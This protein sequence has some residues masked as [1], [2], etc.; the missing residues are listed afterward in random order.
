MR[1]ALFIF[2]VLVSVPRAAWPQG[3]PLGP[4]FRVNTCT[5][6]SFAPFV[7]PG[8]RPSRWPRSRT[9]RRSRGSRRS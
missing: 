2:V 4:A 5:L 6:I 9:S 8:T 3:N 7:R 1:R